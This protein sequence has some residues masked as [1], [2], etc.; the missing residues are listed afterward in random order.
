MCDIIFDQEIPVEANTPITI[1]VRFI[2]PTEE[3]FFCSTLLGYGG[4][5]Y[6]EIENEEIEA[7]DIKETPDCTKF[8]TDV[9]FGQ[10]PR[11]LYFSS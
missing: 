11:I 8:E 4:E 1:M 2:G 6:K 5:N 10:I 7:F 3:D 9:R